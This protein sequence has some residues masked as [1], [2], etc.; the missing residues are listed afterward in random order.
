MPRILLRKP[1]KPTK[2]TKP[3][4][5]LT[6]LP[7]MHPTFNAR[8]I[9]K[10]STLLEKHL[11]EPKQRCKD[12]ISK[13]MLTIEALAEEAISLHCPEKKRTCPK[14]LHGI[15]DRMRQ[16]Q[17]ELVASKYAPAKCVAIA[18]NLRKLRKKLMRQH[19]VIPL[20]L[21]PKNKNRSVQKKK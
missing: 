5:R 20:A 16:W 7:V 2:T 15:P 13:H 17:S 18:T 12:C 10:E 21:L 1:K 3:R 11:N 14:D 19:A 4:K 6:L 9:C 8:Q